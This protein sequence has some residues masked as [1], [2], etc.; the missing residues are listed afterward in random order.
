MEIAPVHAGHSP[1][2]HVL[3]PPSRLCSRRPS[4]SR[5]RRPYRLPA[6]TLPPVPL[7]ATGR[8]LSAGDTVY[9]AHVYTLASERAASPSCARSRLK[10]EVRTRS[11]AS[12]TFDG[13]RAGGG[14]GLGEPSAAVFD[15]AATAHRDAASIRPR[16]SRAAWGSHDVVQKYFTGRRR[17]SAVDHPASEGRLRSPAP[18]CSTALNLP[19]PVRLWYLSPSSS[20]GRRPAVPVLRS[21]PSYRVQGGATPGRRLAILCGRAAGPWRALAALAALLPGLPRVRA[22]TGIISWL[23]ARAR[24][25]FPR[26]PPADDLNPL[27]AFDC[28]TGDPR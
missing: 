21:A 18:T 16:C 27:R 24:I 6:S 17:R 26:R 19:P 20:T 13:C 10:L 23:S 14:A 1:G 4:F 5:V 11:V 12:R 9:P 25:G 7:A 8:V 15:A 2:T 22:A 28:A 3:A